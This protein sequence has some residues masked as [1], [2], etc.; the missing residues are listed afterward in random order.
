[1]G[2]TEVSNTIAVEGEK[3]V[4]L[5]FRFEEYAFTPETA[6]ELGE[7]LVEHAE[8]QLEDEGN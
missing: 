6:K 2:K 8:E 5:S 3:E 7:A 4:R 1:M